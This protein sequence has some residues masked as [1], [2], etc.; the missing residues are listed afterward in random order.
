MRGS[1]IIVALVLLVLCVFGWVESNSFKPETA[2]VRTLSPAFFP[3]A[4][5]I[6]LAICSLLM[7]VKNI[8]YHSTHPPLNWG[9]W[10]KIPIVV[11]VMFLQVVLFEELG[12]LPSAWICL[13]ILLLISGVSF[14]RGLIISFAF[15][16]FVYVF[17][18]LLLRVRLPMELFPTLKGWF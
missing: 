10:Y 1:E 6:G 5:L 15:L 7:I 9:L 14:F 13:V 16:L 4:L 18:I 17:F 12:A 8:L 11:L 3:R 2:M